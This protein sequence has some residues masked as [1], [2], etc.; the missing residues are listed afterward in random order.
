MID[1]SK[2]NCCGCRNCENLCPVEAI[3]MHKDEKGF[4]YPELDYTKCINCNICNNVCPIQAPI[5]LN[6]VK[7]VIAF[8]NNNNSDLKESTSGGAFS[9]LSDII[10]EENGSVFG[11]IMD[12]F[13]AYFIE[14]DEIKIR[15]KMRGSK[16][17]QSDTNQIFY[18]VFLCLGKGKKVLFI[19]TPCQVSALYKYLKYK[20]CNYA[21]LLITIDFICHGVQSDLIIKE[22]V[23][24]LEKRYKKKIIDYKFRPKT[25]GWNSSEEIRFKDG[26]LKS[27]FWISCC[28]D[29]FYKNISLRDSCYKCKYT[30]KT[31]C[32]DITIGDFWDH[33]NYIDKDLKL[34]KGL[35]IVMINTDLG[36][37]Y[38]NILEQKGVT[39][40]INNYN[41]NQEALNRPA[42]QNKDYADFWKDFLLKEYNT[43]LNKYS[44]LSLKRRIKF[45]VKLYLKRITRGKI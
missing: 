31:R 8:Q 2:E 5:T 13:R 23:K 7:K 10:I 40:N 45:N 41:Y 17:I 4:L 18:Q 27:G 28:Q 24:Y 26:S 20:H 35:S 9:A 44:D 42:I 38:L 39:V 19:G 15:N 22:H 34:S 12:A 32:S 33:N 37:K 36:K 21:D 6:N 11:T 43:V 29:F 30:C 16:Y 25:Y 14:T 1:L 3:K